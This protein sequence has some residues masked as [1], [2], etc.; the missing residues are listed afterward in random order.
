MNAQAGVNDYRFAVL[1]NKK[2]E[3]G[4]ALNAASHM[5]AALMHKAGPADREQMKFMD[6]TDA[7]GQIHPVSG[8]SLIVL[9]ADNSNKIRAARLRAMDE[10]ILH[11]DFTE[12][13]TGDTY[14][15]QM[16][17]TGSTQESELYY[18]GLCMFGRKNRIDSITSRFSL[19]R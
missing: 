8:L 16:Q 4:V 15:E 17:R 12:S 18:Y 3:P 2:L 6:Y 5:V 19:W 11:V 7:S 1:L 10:E 14:V 9:R 13:M